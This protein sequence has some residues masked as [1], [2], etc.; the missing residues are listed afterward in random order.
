MKTFQEISLDNS[1]VVSLNNC[2]R[3]DKP[4]TSLSSHEYQHRK[5]QESKHKNMKLT[6]F[7]ENDANQFPENEEDNINQ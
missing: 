5:H 7:K 4:K 3:L 2:N 1:S 6:S